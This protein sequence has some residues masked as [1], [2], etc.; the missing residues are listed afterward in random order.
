MLRS[1]LHCL[2]SINSIYK[3][4]FI[5]PQ[6]LGFWGVDELMMEPCCWGTYTQHREAHKNLRMFDKIYSDDTE[7][8]VNILAKIIFFIHLLLISLPVSVALKVLYIKRREK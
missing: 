7:E 2:N 8:Q 5:I 3:A 6:E 1:V 4:S